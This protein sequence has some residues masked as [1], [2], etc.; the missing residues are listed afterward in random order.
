MKLF[1]LLFLLSIVG[2]INADSSEEFN[3]EKFATDYFDAWVATTQDPS[4]TK[5]SIEYYLLF[6]TDDV[7]HQHFSYDPDGSRYVEGKN[8]MRK[9]MNYYL[10]A[11][12]EYKAKFINKI[13]GHNVLIINY[14][15]ISKGIHP[16]TKQ[17]LEQNHITLEV[18]EIEN[19]K[20]SVNRKYSE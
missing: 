19:R 1:I 5:E 7:R 15:T 13:M 17:A 10:G 6:L 14:E 3:P 4:A 20:V 9:G 2:T 8:S 11:H 12:A 18:L 16:Q